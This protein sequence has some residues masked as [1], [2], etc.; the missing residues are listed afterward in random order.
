MNSIYASNC[1]CQ[2]IW[3]DFTAHFRSHMT[4]ASYQADIVEIME[5]FQK[6]FLEIREE[7][8]K[9][10]FEILSHKV[11]QEN[12]KPGTMAM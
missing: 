4:A 3:P 2:L 5:Y 1:I 10:Y 12:L 6:D 9:E 11:E 8:V 7:E